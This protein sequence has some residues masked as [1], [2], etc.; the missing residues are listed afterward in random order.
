M[1]SLTGN[2]TSRTIRSTLLASLLVAIV[3]LVGGWVDSSA[4]RD[5]SH[6][7]PVADLPTAHSKG[8]RPARLQWA[9]PQADAAIS[10]KLPSFEFGGAFPAAANTF[11][12]PGVSRAMAATVS[13]DAP[14]FASLRTHNPRDPPAP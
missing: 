10:A 9:E 8:Q 4:A 11:E 6:A 3:Y 2:N 7:T 12:R 5:F 1:L 13:R 14:R